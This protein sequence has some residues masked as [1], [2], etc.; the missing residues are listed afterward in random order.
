MSTRIAD[1]R[2]PVPAEGLSRRDLLSIAWR[3][4]GELRDGHWIRVHRRAMAC[5]FEITLSGERAAEIPA[6]REALEEAERLE[7]LLSVFRETSEI[8]RINQQ[9]G[10]GA[11]AASNDVVALLSRCGELSAATGGAFDITSTPLSRCWGFLRRDGRVPAD[12]EIDQ[13]LALVGMDKL[14]CDVETNLVSM[15]TPGAAVNLGAVGKGFAVQAIGAALWRRGVR[16]ALVSAGSSSILALGGADDG[17][18]VDVTATSPTRRV[19]ARLRL[20]NAA[21]GTSG[22]GE[23]FVEV[24]GRRHGHI[25]DPRTGRAASGVVN[26]TVI[27][28]DA[29]TADALA[30]AFFVGGIELARSVLRRAPGH[31]RAH[32]PGRPILASSRCRALPWRSCGGA[33]NLTPEQQAIGRRNF[34]KAVAGVPALAGLGAAAAISGPVRGGP[35]R[36]G[37]IGVGGEG[38]VLLA[39]V[40]PAYATVAAMADINPSQLAKSDEVLQKQGRPAAK[41]YADWQDMIAHEDIEGVVVAVPLWAHADVVCGCL[42]AGKHVLCEKMMAWDVAGCERMR[43]AALKNRK[44]LEIGYQRNYN[45]MYQAAHDGIIKTGLLG[46]VYLSR[47]LW[48]RNGNWRRQGQPPSKDYNPSKWGYPTFEHLWNWRL[49]KKY[50]R[51]LIAELGS[52]EMNIVELV[53]RRG[54]DV[55]DGHRR[56]LPV[57]RRPR[58]ARP[59]L[60]DV[61]V[62]T[63][64]APRSSRR[65]SRTRSTITTR[66]SSARRRR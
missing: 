65:S 56:H 41:H 23:Q 38:R 36:I 27:S 33:V 59:R 43:Q 5:R 21:L 42:D 64:D 46:D 9:A 26:A 51:G 35:M 30:T 49:Y 34:L 20:R 44:V 22:A 55:G 18:R 48:H 58:G 37:F 11:I 29:A 16:E 47:I 12:S 50:S 40:D 13:A 24:N 57:Q 2:L 17:W 54:A 10:I 52:H 25:L 62:P 7:A 15:S 45:P 3:N 28:A 31:A 32:H 19:L 39:Q 61:G 8:S 66:R 53:L 1:P 6:A 60:R 14:S 63:E 4:D